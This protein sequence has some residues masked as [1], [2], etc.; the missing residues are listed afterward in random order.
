MPPGIKTRGSMY[1][2]KMRY[3]R[4]IVI[5]GDDEACIGA[6]GKM[7]LGQIVILGCGY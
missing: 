1:R 2:W 3:G 4:G 7:F 5:V 6:V